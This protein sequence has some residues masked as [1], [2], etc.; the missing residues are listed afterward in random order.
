MLIAEVRR[1][2]GTT[3]RITFISS[4]TPDDEARLAT[5]MLE[6]IGGLLD[7]LPIAYSVRVETTSGTRLER[8]HA[9]IDDEAEPVTA[10]PEVVAANLRLLERERRRMP[11][12]QR[13]RLKAQG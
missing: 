9:P 1:W 11:E 6:A 12:P 5:S 13:S 10:T 3:T 8:S 7:L 4:L 2:R